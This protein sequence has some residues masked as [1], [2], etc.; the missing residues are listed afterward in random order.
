MN[1]HNPFK[2]WQKTKQ[3]YGTVELECNNDLL[4]FSKKTT[5]SQVSPITTLPHLK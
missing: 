1:N 4:S 3:N 2:L 5:M